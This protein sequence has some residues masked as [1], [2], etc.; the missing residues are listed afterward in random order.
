MHCKKHAIFIKL[1]ATF[2]VHEK[3]VKHL[4]VASFSLTRLSCPTSFLPFAP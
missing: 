1:N 4:E 2:L 3:V